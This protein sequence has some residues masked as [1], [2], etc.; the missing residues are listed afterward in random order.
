MENL[1]LKNTLGREGRLR[2]YVEKGRKSDL[3]RWRAWITYDVRCGE[4]FLLLF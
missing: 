1:H 2:I 3:M 4:L